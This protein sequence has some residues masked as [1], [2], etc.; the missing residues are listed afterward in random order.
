MSVAPLQYVSPSQIKTYR[1]C[2]RKWWYEKVKGLPKKKPS[3]GAILGTKCHAEIEQWLIDRDD[4][5][6]SRHAKKGI[7]LLSAYLDKGRAEFKF[8]GLKIG[9]VEVKGIIDYYIPGTHAIVIDHKFKKD[10]V[11]YGLDAE[12][13]QDDEQAIIYSMF[14]I[15]DGA[16]TVEFRH[17]NVQTQKASV[18]MAVGVTFTRDEVLQKFG[19][20]RE[21]VDKMVADALVCDEGGVE[22]VGESCSKWGGC[23]FRDVC[24]IGKSAGRPQFKGESMGLNDFLKK[25]ATKSA[26]KPE[27]AVKSE[28]P[29][30]PAASAVEPVKVGPPDEPAPTA[31]KQYQMDLGDVVKQTPIDGSLTLIVDCSISIP[32]KNLNAVIVATAMQLA[33]DAGVKDIRLSKKEPYSFG[34]WKAVLAA[35]VSEQVTEGI[36]SVDSGELADAVIEVIAGKANVVIRG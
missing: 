1:D 5:K 26:P 21:T 11:A 14:A 17:H 33:E 32:V 2:P 3:A 35:A 27:A 6:L 4:S 8:D 13:L 36:Y 19:A 10:L 7:E 23:D 12:Q 34:G 24:P 16:E 20:L 9:D 22:G 28:T 30:P 31:V 18:G 25:A 15:Q 29:I